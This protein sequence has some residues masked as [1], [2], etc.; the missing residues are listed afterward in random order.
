[1]DIQISTCAID[2]KKGRGELLVI[3]IDDEL[4]FLTAKSPFYLEAKRILNSAKEK[5]LLEEEYLSGSTFGVNFERVGFF[6]LRLQAYQDEPDQLRSSVAKAVDFARKRHFRKVSFLLETKSAS[7]RYKEL[8]D[9]AVLGGYEFS[10]YKKSNYAGGLIV[11]LMLPASENLKVRKLAKAWEQVC[12]SVNLAREIINQP[13]SA[14]T[15]GHLTGYAR[16]IAKKYGLDFHSLQFGELQKEGY[17]GLVNVGKGSVNH[18]FLFSI[19]YRG[20]EGKE[21]D[22]VLVG[23]G[24]TFDTGGISLKP[25]DHMWEMKGDMSGA[26]C[27]IHVMDAIA[28]LK[29]KKNIAIVVPTAENRPGSQAYLPGD[30]LRYRNGK[31]VEIHSTDAEGRLILADAFIYA[32]E[33]FKPEVMIDVATLTGACAR[34][35]GQDYTGLM[36]ND[37]KLSQ[38]LI[39]KG[40]ANGEKI[41]QLALPIEYEED[42]VSPIADIKNVGGALAGAQTAGLFLKHFVQDGVRWA[43]LDIAGTFYYEKRRK[44][45]L[46]PGATG[47]MVRTLTDWILSL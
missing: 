28:K 34:A 37:E 46:Q 8:V 44:Y 20:R 14:M 26:A 3:L 41:W 42:I 45:F 6:P 38:S 33:R 9:G 21:V 2:L 25:W 16:Q 18:P 4:K 17:V 36:A 5:K 43:H 35:L 29:P 1:M 31:T 39:A 32:Q 12:D 24:I 40:Y 23:K 10:A 7:S 11:E 15:P 47:V 13:G 30:I 19:L 27:V 22:A